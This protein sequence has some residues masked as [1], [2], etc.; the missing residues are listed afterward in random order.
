[1]TLDAERSDRALVAEPSAECRQHGTD[2]LSD[3]L[4]TV[5]LTGALFFLVDASFPWGMKVPPAE[6]FSSTI[7]PRAQHVV[8]YHV[9]LKGAGWASI[10]GVTSTWFEAG[11]VIVFPH[12]DRYSMLSEPGQPAEFDVEATMGYFREMAAGRLPFVSKEGGGGEPRSEFVCGFLGCDMQPFNPVLSTLPPLLRVKRSESVSDNL[13]NHLIDLT[14]AEARQTRVGGESIRLRLSELVFVE[15]MR[16]YLE[17]LPADETGWLSGLRDP[18]IGKVLIM[19]HEQPA[20]PWTLNEL[21]S[22][23]CMSRSALAARFT[24]LVGHAPMQYLTLWRMQIAARL[25]ADSSMKVVAVSR[26]IGYESEAAFSRA[27]KKAVGL[28]PA[29]WRGSAAVTSRS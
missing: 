10:P 28:S 3:V 12:G 6:V 15:V 14:L 9:I 11:D 22:R 2:P 16:R 23:A 7:L 18:A 8:S 21:A 20:Y 27:F 26:E 1:M 19:L 24:H 25:L 4:R 13:L 17:T 5:K 29:A